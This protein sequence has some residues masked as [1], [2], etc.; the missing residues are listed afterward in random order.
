MYYSIQT[1]APKWYSTGI[2][3]GSNITKAGVPP[4]PE[5]P[6]P[7]TTVILSKENF[8]FFLKQVVMAYLNQICIVWI[9]LPLNMSNFYKKKNETP[10][11]R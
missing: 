9:P 4:P 7:E 6:T 10:S 8:F 3:W 5:R 11:S 2:D 1:R